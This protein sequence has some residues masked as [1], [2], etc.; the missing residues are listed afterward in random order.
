MSV[1]AFTRVTNERTADAWAQ[2]HNQIIVTD[3]LTVDQVVDRSRVYV[4]ELASLD[5]MVVGC[6]TV[7]PASIEAPVTVIVRILPAYRRR[8]LG[9]AFMAHALTHA[10]AFGADSVQTIV[11][12]SNSDGLVFA[13]RRG[14]VETDRYTMDGDSVP[15]IHLAA[16]LDAPSTR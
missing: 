1:L 6:S 7:R 8:G 13:T 15:Y 14:F 10:R 11:H 5:E 12:A 4:L 16:P 9:S 3:P 2:V